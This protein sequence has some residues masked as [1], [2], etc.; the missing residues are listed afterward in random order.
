MVFN[1]YDLKILKHK[2]ILK[3]KLE[4]DIC[5]DMG[6]VE[7]YLT[8]K[9]NLTCKYC[10]F[11]NRNSITFPYSEIIN[12]IKKLSPKSIIFSGG[13]DPSCYRSE[14]KDISD[15]INHVSHNF[16]AIKLGLITNG[17]KTI[18][19]N[20]VSKLEWLRVSLDAADQKTFYELKGGD[21]NKSIN[22][23]VDYLKN[24]CKYIGIG[25]VFNDANITEIPLFVKLI[26]DTIIDNLD[27]TYLNKVFLEFRPTCKIESCNCQ[28]FRYLDDVIQTH[29]ESNEWNFAIA[30][31]KQIL[32]K[33]NDETYI[34]FINKNSNLDS[35]H[36][37]V[38]A[39]KKI[40]F[41]RCYYCLIKMIIYP[42]GEC[43]PC[44]QKSAIIK[45]SLGNII[46]DSFNEIYNNQ[47]K[48]SQGEYLCSGYKN[49]CNVISQKNAILEHYLNKEEIPNIANLR[50]LDFF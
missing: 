48:C 13:G 43:F 7:F 11:D 30:N 14:N 38:Y 20:W 25:Y 27:E 3:Q 40:H 45:Q 50:W 15:V 26:Y 21:I 24:G 18:Q 31:L 42:N 8:E 10:T 36:V 5:S 2:D 46:N 12:V 22:S 17:Q 39:N 34:N 41:K 49:C 44:V 29:D 47:I 16:P 28:S 9:C 19:G 37:F 1:D 4:G 6:C 32:F 33:E 23:I 35:N